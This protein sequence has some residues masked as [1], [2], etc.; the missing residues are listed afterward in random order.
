MNN[1]KDIILK[2]YRNENLILNDKIE[3]LK[4]KYNDEI[5]DVTLELDKLNEIIKELEKEIN[6]KKDLVS[7]WEVRYNKKNS[8]RLW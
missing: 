4:N 5:N 2:K 8:W 6:K 1:D 3:Y 7:Y